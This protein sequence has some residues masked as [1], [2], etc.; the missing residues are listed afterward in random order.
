M[1]DWNG[2]LAAL[3][4]M[5]PGQYSQLM[6]KLPLQTWERPAAALTA[7][8]K[9]A[10]IV[11]LM[12]Q[13]YEEGRRQLE[14]AIKAVAPHLL[15]PNSLDGQNT[16]DQSTTARAEGRIRLAG[17]CC[18]WLAA[19]GLTEKSVVV[20]RALHHALHHQRDPLNVEDTWTL[21]K[22]VDSLM[23]QLTIDG[24]HPLVDL[25]A[26][27]RW[28]LPSESKSYADGDG[29]IRQAAAILSA[30]H[31][32]AL[33]EAQTAPEL[34]ERIVVI[35][36]QL[37][38]I[39]IQVR[40]LLCTP[41]CE[42]RIVPG[43]E[44]YR[45]LPLE[46]DIGKVQEVAGQMVREVLSAAGHPKGCARRIEVFL[47]CEYLGA[48]AL[49]DFRLSYGVPLGNRAE[50]T[51]RWLDRCL[52]ER[53]WEIEVDTWEAPPMLLRAFEPETL[54]LIARQGVGVAAWPRSKP[55][56]CRMDMASLDPQRKD[57]WPKLAHQAR[58]AASG[59]AP[60]EKSVSVLFDDPS[61]PTTKV[62]Q[63]GDPFETPST[64]T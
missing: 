29:L 40:H 39:T 48:F 17:D 43:E 31:D 11:E 42:R 56:L 10:A 49:D 52:P 9:A 25:L 16:L 3:G 23:C 4:K 50:L 6:P 63:G 62:A 26:L 24:R 54:D 12:Q 19:A 1:T 58:R 51:V 57:E 55:G 38:E 14:A 8:E 30:N 32:L 47:P 37:S 59:E 28:S 61:S 27:V 53:R 15:S 22:I 60:H 36:R 21:K 64:R 2:L 34:P 13:R 44:K 45:L 5:T 41:L 46:S 18:H 35:I 7:G 33:R 20:L